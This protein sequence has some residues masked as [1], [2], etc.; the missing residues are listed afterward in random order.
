MHNCASV[1]L[2]WAPKYQSVFCNKWPASKDWANVEGQRLRK[3]LM[4]LIGLTNRTAESRSVERVCNIV[5]NT[6]MDIIS[7]VCIGKEREGILL[8]K[9][10]GVFQEVETRKGWDMF[11][12]QMVLTPV[13]SHQAKMV[14][15]PPEPVED[16]KYAGFKSKHSFFFPRMTSTWMWRST[17]NP[18]LWQLLAS[19]SVLW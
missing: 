7:N 8:E 11:M 12:P 10:C 3:M 4:Y 17:T 1:F 16:C 14:I 19:R 6:C 15:N 2:T 9:H 5:C 13:L 18:S